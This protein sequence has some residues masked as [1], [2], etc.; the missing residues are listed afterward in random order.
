MQV[1]AS[2]HANGK[3]QKRVVVTGMGVVSCVGQD[4]ET[5]YSNLLAVREC[6]ECMHCK[7]AFKFVPKWRLCRDVMPVLPSGP[8]LSKSR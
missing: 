8:L 3:P 2:A 6:A 4:V 7:A 1:T 5:F